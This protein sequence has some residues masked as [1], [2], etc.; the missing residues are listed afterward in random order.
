MKDN[1]LFLKDLLKPERKKFTYTCL[2]YSTKSA[3]IDKLDDVVDKYNI[4]YHRTIKMMP[5]NVKSSAYID[6]N[7][8]NN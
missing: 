2:Q 5:V 7:K 3:Y 4:I 6:L 8:E 1:L